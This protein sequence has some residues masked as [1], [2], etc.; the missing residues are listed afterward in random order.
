MADVFP[1]DPQAAPAD[2]ESASATP[3]PEGEHPLGEPTVQDPIPPAALQGE[4]LNRAEEVSAPAAPV[5]PQPVL[6]S[7]TVVPAD[8]PT[9]Q[10]QPDGEGGEWDL[11]VSKL[12]AWME[13]VQL[14]E[15]WKQAKSPLT[16]VLA[17]LAVVLV[18][19]IYSS[20]LDVLESLP[21]IPGLLELVG[22]VWVLRFG[23][24]RLIQRNER[25][26]LINNVRE[27]WQRFSGRS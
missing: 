18:L 15:L 4:A 23:I 25:Q 26:T 5:P 16:L 12:Q 14:Q 21:L 20:L 2:Q 7:S 22:L 19:R 9:D 27:S 6:E 13:S 1:D 17:L 8:A 10:K 3:T 11:L 24:P